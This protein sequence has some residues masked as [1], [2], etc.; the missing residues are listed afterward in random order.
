MRKTYREF[1]K[2]Y[3]IPIFFLIPKILAS[4][5]TALGLVVLVGWFSH[6]ETIIQILPI[7]V[8]MQFNTALGFLICGIGLLLKPFGFNRIVTIFGLMAFVIGFSTLLQYI[9][10]INL[11]VDQLLMDHYITIET[12]H[13]GRMAPN[14]ALCFGLTGFTL[15]ILGR[16]NKT[17]KVTMV[18]GIF[19]SII[20]GLGAV[21]F[22]G[23]LSNVETAYG[24]GSLTKMAI[25]TAIGFFM[26]GLGLFMLAW[27]EGVDENIKVPN[28]IIFPVGIGFAT[29]IL[30]M[31]QALNTKIGEDYSSLPVIVLI[32]GL[33]MTIFLV[34]TI[35]FAQI[36][37]RRAKDIEHI[38]WKLKRRISD[39]KK[40][41]EDLIKKE[42]S[43][44]ESE[45]RFRAIFDYANDG[46]LVGDINTKKIV[47]ANKIICK[48]LGYNNDEILKLS[49]HDIHPQKEVAPIIDAFEKISKKKIRVIENLPVKRKDGSIFYSDINSSPVKI[50]EKIY[51]IGILRDITNRK[52]YQEAL[53][54]SEEKYRSMMESLEDAVYICSPGFHIEYMNSAMI[55][56]V[57]YNAIG[58][59]C[60]KAMHG[61]DDKC[62]W[63]IHEKVMEGESI[64]YKTVSPKDNKDY[65]ILNSPI[66][67]TDGSVSKL[68]VFRDVSDFKKMKSRLIQSQKMES[69]GTLAG[70]IAHDFNNILFPIVGHSEM[71]LEDLPKDS[72]FIES[73]Q[74]IHSSALRAKDLVKQI[75]TFSRQEKNE[76]MLLNIQHILKEVLKMIR[77]TM[78][79][80]IE[81]QQDIDPA[82]GPIKADPTQIHQIIMNLATNAYHAMEEH[83]GDMKIKLKEIKLKTN[84][85]IDPSMESGNFACLTIKDTGVGM[86]KAIA[87]KIFDPFFTTKEKDKGTGMGL[88]VVHGIVKSMNGA[89]Q[90][91][92]KPEK[93]TEF[94]VFL[95]VGKANVEKEISKAGKKIQGGTERIFLVDDEESIVTMVK[96][97]LE[98]IGY[99]VIFK[100]NS[101]EALE[102]YRSNPDKFDLIITDLA[103]P[104]MPGDKFAS[105][106]LKI[107]SDAKIILCTGFSEKITPKIASGIGIKGVLLK[108]IIMNSL[109]CKVRE[110]LDA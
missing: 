72:D 82:C 34:A 107:K 6:N 5:S 2:T 57:G 7:F 89:I 93:G 29:I 96:R 88:S 10:N 81:I 67:H 84:E 49:V 55:K 45:E 20:A 36:S 79:S 8:P 27:L 86:S 70:G 46:I 68:T 28:W 59:A 61:L 19:G 48:M 56:R 24:W 17:Q 74:E 66:F 21:S 105:E 104:K 94:N 12:S 102:V 108:P 110:I 38:N 9:F 44:Q 76:M 22:L 11:G 4:L 51:F 95:P 58:E 53:I 40:A 106:V 64:T 92:S 83:G 87:R 50:G 43:L 63:C 42:K 101:L 18:I 54:E 52:N 62:P 1:R 103:M 35:Q 80:T 16:I 32:V 23:Y 25:H 31:W 65:Q 71:L 78:P 75:L 97:L 109:A 41:E 91:Y 69:I 47:F 30:S 99:K 3:C 15:I 60:Y 77:S 33:L 73:A 39:H 14:T 90:V 85:L 37:W 13:P 100:T 26:L 98:R